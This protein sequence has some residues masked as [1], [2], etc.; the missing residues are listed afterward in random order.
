MEL[1]KFFGTYLIT[2]GIAWALLI[3]IFVVKVINVNKKDKVLAKDV[4]RDLNDLTSIGK[5]T[6]QDRDSALKSILEMIFL[7]PIW[8][9]RVYMVLDQI[10]Q[11]DA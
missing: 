10:F 4:D 6:M 7:W 2:G 3:F 1:V 11:Q 5:E 8:V 9:I